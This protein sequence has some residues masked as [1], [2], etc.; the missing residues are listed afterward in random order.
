MGSQIAFWTIHENKSAIS[1]I[2]TKVHSTLSL[3]DEVTAADCKSGEEFVTSVSDSNIKQSL[4]L[5]VVGTTNSIAV[6][7][8]TLQNDI[9]TWIKK[10]DVA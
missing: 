5:L 1:P 9:P 2:V 4:G 8:L 7:T 10:W 3:G 6:Y